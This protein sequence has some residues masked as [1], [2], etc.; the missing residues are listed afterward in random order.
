M[1]RHYGLKP[2]SCGANS[3][4]SAGWKCLCKG[5]AAKVSNLPC[6][7]CAS[8]KDKW[9]RP[10]PEQKKLDCAWCQEINE[11]VVT[12]DWKCYHHGMMTDESLA[13]GRLELDLLTGSLNGNLAM[14]DAGTSMTHIG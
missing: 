4:L 8:H 2:M 9:A 7:C 6:H 12:E 5:G 10:N 13:Q 1:T 11:G 3:D 14:I